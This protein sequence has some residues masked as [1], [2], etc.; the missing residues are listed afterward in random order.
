MMFSAAA[1]FVQRNPVVFNA[2]TSLALYGGADLLAQQIERKSKWDMKRLVVASLIGMI[3]GGFIYPSAYNLL[4][5]T[6]VG[7]DFGSILTKSVVDCATVG[8]LGNLVTMTCH[9]LS[10]GQEK[11]AVLQ[12][13]IHEMPSVT[14]HDAYLWLPYNTLAFSVIPPLIRPATTS[15]L[16]A[17][18]Q[19]YVSMRS[20]DYEARASVQV[21]THR[22]SNRPTV[23]KSKPRKLPKRAL[24]IS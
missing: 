10:S 3:F 17:S 20:N 5:A 14:L 24:K 6:W 8:F 11:M 23:V 16:A 15:L 2:A 18:W 21:T 19:T 22:V 7:K 12:H 1:A 4:D 9:G 13:V